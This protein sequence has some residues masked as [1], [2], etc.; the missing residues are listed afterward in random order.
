LCS[1]ASDKFSNE[2]L[3]INIEVSF[4]AKSSKREALLLSF[5]QLDSKVMNKNNNKE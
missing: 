1:I 3:L 5:S 2:L 4:G